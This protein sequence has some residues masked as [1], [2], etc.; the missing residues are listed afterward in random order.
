MFIMLTL[1][2][3]PSMG[4]M[5]A[6]QF[7]LSSYHWERTT[8]STATQLQDEL[9]RFLSHF[10]LTPSENST[11]LGPVNF[12][13]G[14]GAGCSRHTEDVTVVGKIDL[15]RL[16]SFIIQLQCGE[17]VNMWYTQTL[18][19]VQGIG[20]IGERV[21]QVASGQ[22]TGAM[23]LAPGSTLLFPQ[24]GPAISHN[25]KQTLAYLDA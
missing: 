21:V 25:V 6:G 18:P 11:K 22:R 4:G 15:R 10:T 24:A 9:D 13:A 12:H 14:C 8:Q 16:G 1:V 2:C 5:V 19:K 20:G 23:L 7:P 3:E 17:I